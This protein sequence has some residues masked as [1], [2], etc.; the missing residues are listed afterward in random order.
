MSEPSP[1]EQQS[2]RL[3]MLAIG[4]TFVIGM[5]ALFLLSEPEDPSTQAS[6]VRVERPLPRR[7]ARS[8]TAPGTVQITVQ[9]GGNLQCGDGSFREVPASGAVSLPAPSGEPMPCTVSRGRQLVCSGDI[10]PAAA[11][12]S[13]DGS[14]GRLTCE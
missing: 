5:G 4:A 3:S 9:G 8:G 13:C 6:E 11:R 12:C 14:T 2:R 7:G 1:P 10:P